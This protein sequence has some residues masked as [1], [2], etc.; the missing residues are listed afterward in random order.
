MS[1]IL[2]L[3][4]VAATATAGYAIACWLAKMTDYAERRDRERYLRPAGEHQGPQS[5]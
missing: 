1:K 3:T 4:G 2:L 5:Q